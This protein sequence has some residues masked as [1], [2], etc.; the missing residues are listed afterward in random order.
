MPSSSPEPSH[1]PLG[2]FWRTDENYNVRPPTEAELRHA[3][4]VRT[5][6]R[7]ARHRRAP[8]RRPVRRRGSQRTTTS[9][10]DPPGGGDDDDHHLLED[11]LAGGRR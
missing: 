1:A 7:V 6:C 10:G 2:P 3:R 8:G 4:R 5:G 11:D 9:R